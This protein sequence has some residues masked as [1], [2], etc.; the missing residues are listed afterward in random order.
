MSPLPKEDDSDVPVVVGRRSARLSTSLPIILR[1]VDATGQT[2]KENTWTISVNKQGAR[3]ATFYELRI[4]DQVTIENPVL[5]RTGKA[6]VVRVGEKR[7]PEDPFDIGVELNEAQNV[8]GVK[9]PPEN[10]Q[11]S[12]PVSV[13]VRPVEATPEAVSTPRALRS[14]LPAT[15]QPAEASKPARALS[16]SPPAPGGRAEGAA[17]A[18]LAAEVPSRVPAPAEKPRQAPTGSAQPSMAAQAE[19][20]KLAS[21]EEATKLLEEKEN[22]LRSLRQEFD[23]LS[24]SVRVSH[25]DLEALLARFQELQRTWQS[26]LDR[27]QVH[28]QQF[29]REAICSATEQAKEG[30]RVTVE[31]LSSHF[32][33]ETRKRLQ[34]E[35]EVV[36]E[37]SS[38]QAKARLAALVEEGLSQTEP[39]LQTHQAR[40]AEQVSA[41]ISR[42]L[43]TA[44]AEFGE[45]LRK[46]A[47]EMAAALHPEMEKSLEGLAAQFTAQVDRTFQARAQGAAETAEQ[48]FRQNLRKMQEKVQEEIAGANLKAREICGQEIDAARKGAAQDAQAM[49]ESM[50]LAAEEGVTKLRAAQAEIQSRTDELALEFRRQVTELSTAPLE[51]FQRYTE[52]RTQDLQSEL[53]TAISR[54]QDKAVQDAKERLQK[55]MRELM[56][57]SAQLLQTQ[58][59]DTLE[60]VADRLKTLG[61]ESQEETE[62]QLGML[63]RSTRETLTQEARV[64]AQGSREELRRAAQEAQAQSLQE[65]E[66]HL[67]QGAEKQ[68]EAYLKQ[69]QREVDQSCERGVADLRDRV[70][71]A[72]LEASEKV[73]KHVGLVAFM[74]KEWADQAK[75]NLDTCLQGALES[76]EKQRAELFQEALEKHRQESAALSEDLRSRLQQAARI[77]QDTPRDENKTETK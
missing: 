20:Q 22:L 21:L 17:P 24:N 33:E 69:F 8:W 47:D 30:L 65:L 14:S 46:T 39:Q 13:G 27:T 74:M 25:A 4:G 18:S 64:L 63:A 60:Q 2:F 32:I 71:R 41:H 3:I 49:R 11:R 45:R 70:Q 73:Y 19:S 38:Q 66:T 29:S 72:A 61:K 52:A 77:L 6:H 54:V 42:L 7:Y 15:L 55:T 62:K 12:G 10:W 57:S 44:V 76:F 56:D 51:R 43:Q 67:Q 50:R 40:A 59:D 23:V 35:A 28:M 31:E 53:Q 5:G 36:I 75:L 58:A 26:E 48:S 9:F 34:A 1:G 37:A 68:R 16:A